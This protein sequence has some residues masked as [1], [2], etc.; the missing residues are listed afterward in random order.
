MARLLGATVATQQPAGETW[1]LRHTRARSAN[2]VG[3]QTEALSPT[4]TPYREGVRPV[5]WGKAQLRGAP[6]DVQE[7]WVTTGVDPHPGGRFRT[8]RRQHGGRSSLSA[9]WSPPR[10][11]DLPDS[12]L[13]SLGELLGVVTSGAGTVD[14]TPE[15]PVPMHARNT[16][17]AMAGANAR[18]LAS[19]PPQRG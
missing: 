16:A 9:G 19:Q 3:I 5:R 7:P 15:S 17:M 13:E 6:A 11:E 12:P 18:T 14:E 8:G 10:V 2:V 4:M 1:E